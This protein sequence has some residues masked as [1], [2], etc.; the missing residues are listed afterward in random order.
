MKAEK[1]G[2]EREGDFTDNFNAA[3]KK[4]HSVGVCVLQ[5]HKLLV[6]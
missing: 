1:I 2:D 6:T 5:T 3:Y 4:L